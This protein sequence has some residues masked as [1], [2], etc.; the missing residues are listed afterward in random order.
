MSKIR[1]DGA[2]TP[3]MLPTKEDVV[4]QAPVGILKDI[5]ID[6]A[7]VATGHLLQY[8]A[9]ATPDPVWEN[10]NVIDGGTY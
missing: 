10:S 8:N 3:V 4:T 2:E 9:A 1:F 7:T 5:I 6:Q